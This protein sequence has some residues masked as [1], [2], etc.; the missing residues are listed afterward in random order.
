MIIRPVGLKRYIYF[1]IFV[2]S[3]NVTELFRYLLSILFV[4]YST[5]LYSDYNPVVGFD[6]TQDG[7]R[8]TFI[9]HKRGLVLAYLLIQK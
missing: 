6:L 4:L 1:R 8:S 7:A 2:V 9:C 3:C 5:K